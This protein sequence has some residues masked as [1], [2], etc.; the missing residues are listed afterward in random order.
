MIVTLQCV[1]A[2]P[3]NRETT[4]TSWGKCGFN[5]FQW[6]VVCEIWKPLKTRNQ[7]FAV[8][9]K[10]MKM[11]GF[12]FPWQTNPL[13]LLLDDIDWYCIFMNLCL[14][15]VCALHAWCIYRSI[16]GSIY[17]YTHT[18]ASSCTYIYRER[19]I[20]VCAYVHVLNKGVSIYIYTHMYVSK[21][22]VG[23]KPHV[24]P[25]PKNTP[26]WYHILVIREWMKSV[27]VRSDFDL[28]FLGFRV[29]WVFGL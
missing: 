21:R 16:Y 15:C 5:M 1:I 27:A 11:S 8:H 4:K 9:M 26:K 18:C 28:R 3:F 12:N 13:N 7:D 22:H 2:P 17:W 29:F 24:H 25:H 14:F 6:F 23:A 20:Y 10:Y 19:Y